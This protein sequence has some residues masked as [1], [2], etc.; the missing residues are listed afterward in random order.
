MN[1]L[2]TGGA[3]G[4]GLA[5]TEK[6][7]SNKER[8]VFFTYS[9]SVQSAKQLEMTFENAKAIECNFEK[10]EQLQDLITKID[11]LNI[12][13]LINNAFAGAIT[14]QHFHKD[15]TQRFENGFNKNIVPVIQ[16]TQKAITVFRKK[17]FGKIITVL[18]SALVNKPPVGWSEYVAGKAYLQSLSKSWATEN[19]A[20]NIS[21][22]C[23]LPAFMQTELTSDVDER[24]IEGMIENHPLKK[25]LTTSEV[26]D[27]VNYLVGA[28]QQINGANMII[29]SASDLL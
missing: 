26:A 7:C 6:L 4:L 13:V 19:V 2:I 14:K 22:N 23:V 1:I 21:S 27:A 11:E 29:N 3:S 28:P 9:G 20:F 5:I 25:L 15:G 17:K 24:I 8:R 16:I 18:T 10:P 12:D